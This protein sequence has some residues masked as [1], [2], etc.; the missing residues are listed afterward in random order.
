[1]RSSL[2]PRLDWFIPA[3]LK[4]DNGTL[5]RA[6]IFVVS[7]LLGTPLAYLVAFYLYLLD[8]APGAALGM[9]VAIITLFFAY[10]VALRS[11]GRFT[12]LAFLSVQQLSCLVLFTAYEYGGASSPFLSLVLTGPIAAYF[13][14]GTQ[15][16]LRS[17]C[18]V[19]L[20][21][22]L[23][24]FY[25]VHALGYS[26]PD[27]IPVPA[28][29]E[30]GV[31]S[32]FCAAVYLSMLSLSHANIVAAQQF[33]LERE[34]ASRRGT[35]IALRQAKDAAEELGTSFRLLFAGNP[36]PMWVWDRATSRFLEVNE[37]AVAQYGYSREQFLAM[38]VDAIRPPDEA[39]RLREHLA[40]RRADDYTPF[41]RP[42][43][44]RHRRADGSEVLVDILSHPLEFQG[45]RAHLV[46]AVDVTDRQRSE[47]ALRDGE[48]RL[49]RILD[50]A[51]DAFVSI[52]IAGKITAWN[53][54]AARIFGWSAEEVVGR[55]LSETIIPERFRAAHEAG[56]K[57]F[58]ETGKAPV[59]GKRLEL[60]ALRRDGSEFAVEMTI[61]P[62][63]GAGGTSFNAFIHDITD[64]REREQSIRDSEARYRLLAENATDVIT[65]VSLDGVR[66]YV[67][68][69][70]ADVLGY[71]PHEL[72]GR[73]MSQMPH[74]E[75][76]TVLPAITAALQRGEEK[77]TATFRVRR[78]DDRMIWFETSL[79][80]ARDP[81]T[82]RPL[83]IVAV[84]RDVSARHALQEQL[85]A[86]KEEAERASRAKSEFLA[87]MSHELRTPLNAILGFG[88]L[89]QN[90]RAG[91]PGDPRYAEY[92]RDIVESGRHLLDLINEILDFAKADAG[93]LNLIDEPLD[94]RRVVDACVHMLSERA[95]RG[96]L[97]LA[98][99]VAPNVGMIRGDER[100][101]K[102]V[103]LNLMSNSIKF[104]ETGGS[105]TVDAKIDAAG[106]L[107]VSVIDTGIGIA[108]G[109]V[110]KVLQP[111][112]QVDSALNRRSEGT[113][114]GLPLAKR[115]VE[116]HGGTLELDSTPGVGTTTRFILP[117]DRIL[118]HVA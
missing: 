2:Y 76:P 107:A 86:A 51:Y 55:S 97:S 65:R 11:T 54:A 5:R 69:S 25:L 47:A 72:V 7:H 58:S 108:A 48:A 117:A 106:R 68:P 60:S 70:V 81:A 45:H 111:F 19:L 37:A 34:V 27:R 10:P 17:I 83:E 95:A 4:A 71:E 50:N 28:M 115:L 20:A 100:R 32:V 56:L 99:R 52:D 114:L 33:D 57:H 1:M 112:E 14:F 35:E 16:R 80:L 29:F 8:P 3:P 77:V 31:F 89:V 105:V 38:T 73:P 18:L 44:W 36:I 64:R 40:K 49:R 94:L 75:D 84:S 87:N 59:A 15:P 113:G 116:L 118:R 62:L 90:Q 78:K 13:Y 46:A 41:A 22:D 6:R 92:G 104:T 26:A 9:I 53:S 79:Q 109:D 24:A 61:S 42:G 85:A 39:A 30:V 102:Q 101:L 103:L 23:F 43:V 12:L 96:G 93:H 110:A 74:P 66:L 21:L 88:E 91:P 67:S 63:A 82:G 98:S